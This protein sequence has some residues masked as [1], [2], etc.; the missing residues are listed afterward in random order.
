[1]L[2]AGL[3]AGD[4]DAAAAFV[5]RFQSRVYGLALT[6]LRDPSTAE[7][8]AQEGFVRAWRH[9]EKYDAGRASVLAWLLG[10][11]RNLA[12]DAIRRR[13]AEPRDPNRIATELEVDDTRTSWEGDVGFGERDWLRSALAALPAEQ[14]RAVLLAAYLGRTAD[15]I[16]TLE[17]IPLGTA[18]TRIRRGMAKLRR[19]LEVVGEC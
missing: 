10:I 4:R 3:A 19:E 17:G 9:A 2:L 16:A 13:G 1:V 12:I 15:E 6:I 8:I 18:K 14:R 11:V 7:D 5:R